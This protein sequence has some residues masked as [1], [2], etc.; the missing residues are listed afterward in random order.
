MSVFGKYIQVS[1]FGAS[2]EEYIGITIHN[3]PS[4][5]MLNEDKISKKLALRRGLNYLTS[6][7]FE[8]DEFK[9]ISGIYNKHTTGAPITILVKN[10]DVLSSE[11]E[12]QRGLARPSHADYTY[13]LKYRGFNDYRGGGTA[14]GRL[15][16]ALIVLGAFCEEI[17]NT[18]NIIIASRMKQIKHLIDKDVEISLDLLKKLKEEEFPVFD[19]TIK[20]EMLEL[21][22]KTKEE[23]DSLG[24][25]IQT[26]IDNL[27]IGLGEPFWDSFESIISHLIFSIPGVK[28]IEFGSGFDFVHLYGSEANDG[29][30]LIN[31][32]VNYLSNHNGGINGGITNGNLVVF[33][34]VFKPTSSIGKPQKTIDFLKNENKIIEISG[35]HDAIIA[36]KGLHVINALSAYAVLE[37]LLGTNL[38]NDIEKK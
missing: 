6:K 24:G 19:K 12:K 20:N 8:K 3:Y 7:R 13:H 33:N 14:S 27:P 23:D 26:Y 18:K 11:Y 28:G 5:I 15:T 1:L 21:I 17:L 35:R 25:I 30:E 29:L 10:T 16:V 2:H 22:S 9:I 38:W 32:K 36:I 31:N 37:L 4:G 34:T